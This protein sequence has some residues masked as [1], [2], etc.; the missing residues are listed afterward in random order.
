M[1]FLADSLRSGLNM[2]EARAV[3]PFHNWSQ[4]LP[5]ISVNVL[6]HE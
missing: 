4:T 5:T 3:H 1:M 2:G 6:F